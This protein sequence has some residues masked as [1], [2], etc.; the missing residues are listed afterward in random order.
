M[1]IS[2]K[3]Q[4]DHLHLIMGGGGSICQRINDNMCALRGWLGQSRHALSAKIKDISAQPEARL[5]VRKLKVF[6]GKGRLQKQ[7][8]NQKEQTLPE[9]QND[10]QKEKNYP[11]FLFCSRKEN[12]SSLP[13]LV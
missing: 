12:P 11:Y 10:R 4:L 6:S 9:E 7:K 13:S 8:K 5:C 2:P 1:L 3:T